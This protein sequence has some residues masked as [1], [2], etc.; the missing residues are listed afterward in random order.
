MVPIDFPT[1]LKAANGGEVSRIEYSPL[2]HRLRAL[3][4]TYGVI[5]NT[6]NHVL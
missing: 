1:V 2:S 4:T 5:V 6:D 3:S